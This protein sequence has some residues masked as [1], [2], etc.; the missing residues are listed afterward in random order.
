[1]S[2]SE[3]FISFITNDASGIDAEKCVNIGYFYDA[4][5]AN[6]VHSISKMILQQDLRPNLL[7]IPGNFK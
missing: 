5:D 2:Y 4:P 3:F 6:I 7:N 1:M